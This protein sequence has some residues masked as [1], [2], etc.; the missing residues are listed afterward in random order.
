MRDAH[1][2]NDF[3]LCRFHT[4]RRRRRKASSLPAGGSCHQGD[5]VSPV[6]LAAGGTELNAGLRESDLLPLSLMASESP[7][8]C[9]QGPVDYSE[10][11][12][13]W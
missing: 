10:P 12:L 6:S 13:P 7:S 5:A 2:I 9:G 8:G 4:R 11:L 3:R 1:N